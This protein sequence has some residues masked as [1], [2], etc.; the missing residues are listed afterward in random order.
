MVLLVVEMPFCQTVSPASSDPEK[1]NTFSADLQP[2]EFV[3]NFN[4]VSGSFMQNHQGNWIFRGNN[5]SD[6]KIS[7]VQIDEHIYLSLSNDVHIDDYPRAIMGFNI[8]T[9]DGTEYCFGGDQSAVDFSYALAPNLTPQ[10]FQTE[11]HRNVAAMGWHLT[12][13]KYV[14]GKIIEF[15]YEKDEFTV[16]GN[17][18]RSLGSSTT[19]RLGVTRTPSYSNSISASY[20]FMVNSYLTQ[21]NTPY[22][23]IKFERTALTGYADYPIEPSALVGNTLLNTGIDMDKRKWFKLTKIQTFKNPIAS[24]TQKPLVEYQLEYANS[25]SQRLQLKTIKQIDVD[26]STS[27]INQYV[28]GYDYDFNVLPPYLSG[29]IDHW[30]YFNNSGMLNSSM[31]STTTDEAIYQT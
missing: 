21:I 12:K 15:L 3:F 29:K 14:S 2:D 6:F 16:V 27:S 18:T 28:F 23:I 30:G 8:I 5:P 17:K 10:N 25:P 11:A 31:L 1:R 26:A 9:S 19:K 20:S 4:G 22:E 24:T 7:N 13:I